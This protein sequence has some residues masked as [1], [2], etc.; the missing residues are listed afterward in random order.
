MPSPLI[1]NAMH[2]RFELEV[3]PANFDMSGFSCRYLWALLGI[4]VA[5]FG[6]T[7]ALA[8]VLFYYF[9]PSGSNDCSFNITAI[10]F[11]LFLGC[12]ITAISMS[13]FVSS[14]PIASPPLPGLFACNLGFSR[15]Y[16]WLKCSRCI[17]CHKCC[18]PV[19]T[20][21]SRM[22]EGRNKV[23][24]DL[25]MSMLTLQNPP[26]CS[27]CEILFGRPIWSACS[28]DL[29]SLVL[30]QQGQPSLVDQP[31]FF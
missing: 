3:D 24:Y 10:C 25:R 18:R 14:H 12:I 21:E 9:N 29:L 28:Y 20:S 23:W 19:H 13:P 30:Y 6:G 27:V 26:H 15:S 4:T 31:F 1:G 22:D 7:I 17:I 8:G 16:N 5:A 2:C 11:T